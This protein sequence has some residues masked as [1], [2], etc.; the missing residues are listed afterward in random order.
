MESSVRQRD[1]NVYRKDV[2]SIEV[3]QFHFKY[4]STTTKKG[5]FYFIFTVWE[6]CHIVL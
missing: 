2:H 1:T 6:F 5:I 4:I 3:F